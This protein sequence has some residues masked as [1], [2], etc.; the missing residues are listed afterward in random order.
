MIMK[1]FPVVLFLIAS[2]AHAEDTGEFLSKGVGRDEMLSNCLACHSLSYITKTRKTREGWAKTVKT[3]QTKNGL[4]EIE[5]QTLANILSYLETHFGAA[6]TSIGND[7]YS[8][9]RPLLNPLSSQ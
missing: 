6:G 7:E 8:L 1:I 5:P 2:S 3:M 9:I 4:W